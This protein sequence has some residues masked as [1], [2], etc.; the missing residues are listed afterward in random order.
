[1]KIGIIGA[2][3]IGS[4]LARHFGNLKRTVRIAN[5]RGPETLSQIAKDTG[6]TP[7]AISDV[8]EGA[9]LLV[10][11]IPVKNV[12]SLPRD[13]LLK[14]P[15]KSP[16]LDTDNYYPLRDGVIDGIGADMTES[17][18]TSSILGRP[19]IKVLNN[20]TADSLLHKGMPEWHEGPHCTSGIGGG[21][22]CEE[23]RNRAAG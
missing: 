21:Y 6:A 17:E 22:R 7:V 12:P 2:G 10:V 4:A 9:D 19:V 11:T 15:S 13:L 14:L 1:M 20:I 3:N 16:I 23:A 18:W 5:S 8:A